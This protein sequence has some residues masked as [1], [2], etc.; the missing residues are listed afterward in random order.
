MTIFIDMD[1]EVEVLTKILLDQRK[2]VEGARAEAAVL[3]SAHLLDI[4]AFNALYSICSY[5]DM[6][7]IEDGLLPIVGE[8]IGT[9]ISARDLNEDPL[10]HHKLD[11]KYFDAF[12]PDA[13]SGLRLAREWKGGE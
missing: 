1:D 10:K 7:A 9:I 4:R 3:L 8:S 2:D 6:N 13:L 5:P 12:H 11:P